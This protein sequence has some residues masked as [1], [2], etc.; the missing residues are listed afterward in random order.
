MKPYGI[1]KPPAECEWRF[2]DELRSPL[3]QKIKW[4]RASAAKDAASLQAGA[5]LD[6]RFPDPSQR[7]DTAHADFRRFL[8]SVGI[9]EKPCFKIVT[10]KI[11]TPGFETYRIVVTHNACKILA[12]DTE[13]IRRGLVHVEDQMLRSGGPFLPLGA[14]ER[15]PV[16]RSRISR[17]FF[18]PIKRPPANRDELADNVNYYPD[19]YLNRLA[20][21]GV[22][23]LWLTV[24]F[25]DLCPTSVIPEY[26]QNDERRLCKLKDTVAQCLRYGIKI[27]A[28]CIEPA[29]FPAGSPI[30]KAHPELGGHASSGGMTFFC[31]STREGLRHIEEATERLFT[32]VP[33]LGGLINISVGERATNC[34][35]ITLKCNC[36]RC[37]KRKP[38]DVLADMLSAM[39]RGMHAGN[40]AAELIS[41]PY[42]QY[43]CWGNRKTLESAQFMPKGVILQHNFESAGGKMQLGK[44]RWAGDYWLAYAGPSPLFRQCAKAVVLNGGRMFA[45]LQVGCS[46]EVASIPFVPVP[47]ILYEKYRAMRALGVSGAMQ[48]WYFGSYPSIMT[49]AAGEL[50]F[51]SFPGSKAGFLRY[52]AQRDW[53][54]HASQ[55][56]RAWMYFEMGYKNYPLNHIFGYYGPMHNGPVWP[57]Y[58]EPK[59][60]PLAPNWL[61]GPGRGD[62]AYPPS[63]DRIGECV[64]WTHTLDEILTLCGKMVEN[65][66]KGTAILDKIKPAHADNPDRLRD[67][68]VCQAL[69][70][71]FRSGLN[72]LSFYALREKLWRERK[73]K[74]RVVLL[75]RMK[76]SVHS[77]LNADGKLLLLAESDSRLG[78]NSEAETHKYFPA[79]I[80]WRMKQLQR[81]LHTEFPAVEKRCLSGAPLFPHY[82][83]EQP[84]GPS[85]QCRRLLKPPEPTGKPFGGAWEQL[86][87]AKCTYYAELGRGGFVPNKHPIRRTYW[88]AGYDHKALYFGIWR[89]ES[90]IRS[91]RVATKDKRL[92]DP[93]LDDWIEVLIEP[94][95]LWPHYTFLVNAAGNRGHRKG[96]RDVI[97]GGRKDFYNW[98]ARS[99]FSGNT[100]SVTMR[101]PFLSLGLPNGS[102]WPLRIDVGRRSPVTGLVTRP[103]FVQRWI[104]PHP[105]PFPSR[106]IYAADNPK[107]LGWLLF[108]ED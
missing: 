104:K 50:S 102:R 21:E 39:K 10:D 97:R 40:P 36:P 70:L 52:L 76:S 79:L 3:H 89:M 28:F 75:D 12:A 19:E 108:K 57:L 56:A 77:E 51:A 88:K 99:C 55:V 48:C 65:W 64:T 69:G 33:N 47:G 22:N 8:R 37:S 5:I 26:V 45:K 98:Q 95:R 29:G 1:P 38:W 74:R 62:G 83:G 94:R 106:M 58:L 87:P 107:D 71:Q 92:E 34:Y 101:I 31:T 72:I 84:L 11:K 15:I 85:Y 24:S 17:C 100:W 59:D 96:D 105:Y 46:H 27:Y 53:G 25:A 60:L 82:T 49:K 7:L 43:V 68:G 91:L 16:I 35:S 103:P 14:I 93:G 6:L 54:Q 41:W 90:D 42:S 61:A 44:W 32:S 2:V 9:E 13:G 4:E 73:V 67:I 20:H 86:A 78:F 30:L 81:L 18:G 66:D 23:G 80:R 63:G